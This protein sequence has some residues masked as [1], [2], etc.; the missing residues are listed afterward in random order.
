M[1]APEPRLSTEQG[2]QQFHG[3][4]FLRGDADYEDARVGRVFNAARPFRFPAAVLE[5]ADTDDVVAG[6]RLA[7]RSGW[8]VSIRSGGH[9]W[10]AWSVRDN[11]L[12]I[13]LG[14]LRDISYDPA[15]GVAAVEPAVTG[16]ELLPVLAEHGR[17]F[18]SGHAPGVGL[19][20]Y[21]LQG[22]AGWN[23]RGWG[24]ACEHVVG[25]DVVTADGAL[26][27]ATADTSSDLFWAARGA[28]HGFFGVATRFHL[29][30]RPLPRA[31]MESFYAFGPELVDDVLSWALQAKTDI[32]RN[33]EFGVIGSHI[34]GH[35]Q[36][37][38]IYA[39]A[40]ADTERE[41]AASLT[42]F[43]SSLLAERATM[44][45]VAQPTT[46]QAQM[47]RIEQ[48]SP[49][50]LRYLSDS[51]WMNADAEQTVPLLRRAFVDLPTEDSE[52]L[53][54][55]FDRTVPL[56]DMALSLQTDSYVALFPK[57]ES[58][59]DDHK[60]RSWLED[61]MAEI[62]PISQ[63]VFLGDCDLTRRDAPFMADANR[64]RL[65]EIRSYRDPS[66]VFCSFMTADDLRAA[67][68]DQAD[69]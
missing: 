27:H 43:D 56:P 44:K 21:L 2:S 17:M 53:W 35:G 55:S 28:G 48:Q 7:R 69:A 66:G 16:S 59:A 47:A 6:I 33:V 1:N 38:S 54:V 13:D 4:L 63:G 57:W 67:S 61:R 52:A 46:L 36:M 24:W 62:E 29:K 45:V 10:P 31:I 41:A 9:S 68:K 42:P 22:G 15:T 25:I 18:Q 60:C 30:T 51:A 58:V 40:F 65:E 8:R 64:R 23:T 37:V 26:V 50:T 32:P 11:A 19:G 14:R 3:R 34:P 39:L 5:V 20:G 12:L 49:P